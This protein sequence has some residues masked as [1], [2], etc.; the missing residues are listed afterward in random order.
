M[1][2]SWLPTPWLP[3]AVAVLGTFAWRAVL[4]ELAPVAYSFDGYQ[5]WA[6]RDH[7]LVQ[8]W[9]PVTQALIWAT[10]QLGGGIHSGRHVMAFVAALAAG[11]G[12]LLAQRI[13]EARHGPALAVYTGWAFVVASFFGPWVSWGTVFY[14]ES[15]FLLVLF[16]G[17]HLALGRRPMFGDLVMGLL[18][19]VRYEGWP[20]ILI[21]V[22]WRQRPSAL[23]AFWGM[24]VWLALRGAGVEGYQASPVNFADWEGLGARFTVA[25]WA[26]D[27]FMFGWRLLNSGG[28]V[29]V[30]LGGMV[31]W[32][33]RSLTGVRIVVLVFVSQVAITA[34]W[35]AGL[36]VSTSRMTVIPVAVMAVLGAGVAP[37]LV[38]RKRALWLVPVGLAIIL[39]VAL[40]DARRRMRVESFRIKE[41][42]AAL[43]LMED[44][45]GCTWWVLP[46]RNM[47]TRSRH[48][49]CEVIQGISDLIA[50]EDFYCAPWVPSEDAMALYS[51]CAG[52]IRWDPTTQTYLSERHLSGTAP[53]LPLMPPD[54]DLRTDNAGE[55]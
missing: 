33:N 16:A 23:L 14:Q 18:G 53:P 52:T 5:R 34:A 38:V 41:E 36:E 43:R 48:D 42:T 2:A 26:D 4:L 12:T 25:N 22:A 1:P 40:S 31:A 55:E 6:G 37:W 15:T 51:G 39:G 21:Y 30:I 24:G 50:G 10:A 44:C 46:R 20:V 28:F 45:P 49:G 54:P 17:L 7:V 13:S 8:S 9:L 32:F 3:A 35:L 47:G 19:L 27:V 11:A 29:W